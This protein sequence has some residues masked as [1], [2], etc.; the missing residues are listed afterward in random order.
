MLNAK[1]IISWPTGKSNPFF[2]EKDDFRQ[3]NSAPAPKS[4][5]RRARSAKK[6]RR[7]ISLP[8]WRAARRAGGRLPAGVEIGRELD[9]LLE[10]VLGLAAVL[11]GQIGARNPQ[12]GGDA[13]ELLGVVLLHL[14]LERLNVA[15]AGG[16][17][18]H[19]LVVQLAGE[20]HA[21]LGFFV[22]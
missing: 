10:D 12:R 7:T 5:K 13:V 22:S 4:Q 1:K 11:L 15:F 3:K 16:E 21:L 20:G 14:R 6:E 17:Q 2:T 8:P 19:A 9:D 18:L